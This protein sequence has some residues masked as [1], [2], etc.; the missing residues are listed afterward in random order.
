MEAHLLK[1]APVPSHMLDHIALLV[2]PGQRH[3][4]AADRYLNA[5][6]VD[7]FP[8]GQ[9]SRL[10]FGG[11]TQ[12]CYSLPWVSA[13]IHISR[14]QHFNPAT[15]PPTITHRPRPTFGCGGV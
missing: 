4:H 10:R 2:Q 9:Y 1:K 6:L 14:T 15:H 5:I 13:V 8:C 12:A 11:K 3:V 7:G